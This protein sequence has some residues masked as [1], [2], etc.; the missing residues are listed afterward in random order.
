VTLLVVLAILA[1]VVVTFLSTRGS[2]SGSPQVQTAPT[3][4]GGWVAMAPVT[5]SGTPLPPFPSSGGDP[6]IGKPFP[7][8]SGTEVLTGKPLAIPSAG[9]PKL[10]MFIA[11]WC[12][13]CQREVP[14]LQQWLDQKGAPSGLD[15]YAVSTSVDPSRGNYPPAAWLTKEHWSVPT[16]ADSPTNDAEVAAGLTG[17]P[18]FVA[19]G[20]DGN[21]VKRLAGER[22]ISEI[23]A[24]IATLRA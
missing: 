20:R 10:V 4:Q 18:F 11:H 19:V 12:P 3:A 14:L 23:E 24:L 7:T 17:F 6:A 8:L 21:V 22:S 16:L 9:S 13:H 2:G 5:V 15:L 1:A